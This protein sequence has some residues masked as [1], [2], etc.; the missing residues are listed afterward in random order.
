MFCPAVIILA[1]GA[2]RRMGSPKLLLPWGGTTVLGHLIRQ[3]QKLKVG[4]VGVVCSVQ[5]P[6]IH[7]EL[8]S[9]R[10]PEAN[11][12]INPE[13]ERGMLS[14]IRC[15]AAWRG[16]RKEITHWIITLGDQPH[17]QEKTLRALLRFGS[18]HP[19]NIC[20]PMRKGRPRH[21]VLLPEKAFVALRNSPAGNLKEFLQSRQN[22]KA[23]FESD[24]AGL[25]FDM[26]EPADYERA[27]SVA[28]V[29]DRSKLAR[30]ARNRH[31]QNAA[32]KR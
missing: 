18:A 21:P 27:M 23:G 6:G 26:D 14:S 4:Q 30:E 10:F 24:D 3:W 13:P 31:P 8:D 32:A 20:Q 29:Y 25:D 9:L 15:A 19:D 2:S 12:I 1:A 11:R 22:E 16:W 7:D 28:E 5:A 17:L